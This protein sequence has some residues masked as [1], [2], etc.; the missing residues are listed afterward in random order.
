MLR[1]MDFNT[2]CPYFSQ[3]AQMCRSDSPRFCILIIREKFVKYLSGINDISGIF[4]N[5]AIK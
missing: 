3:S 1:F 4:I 5:F 2:D